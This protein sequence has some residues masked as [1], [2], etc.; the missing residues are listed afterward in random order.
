MVSCAKCVHVPTGVPAANQKSF[1]IVIQCVD[2]FN[3]KVDK[4]RNHSFYDEA[5]SPRLLERTVTSLKV[6][7][8]RPC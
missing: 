8:E 3:I 2:I 7:I 4:T 5:S 6:D 1:W